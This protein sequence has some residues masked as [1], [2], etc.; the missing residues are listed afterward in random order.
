MI[1]TNNFLLITSKELKLKTMNRRKFLKKSSTGVAAAAFLP[2]LS[3]TSKRYLPQDLYVAAELFEE[4]GRKWFFNF[5]ISPIYI[6]ENYNDTELKDK[7]LILEGQNDSTQVKLSYKIE[8]LTQKTIDDKRLYFIQYKTEK[9][10]M[11]A[12][13]Y[14]FAKEN[15]GKEIIL[16]IHDKCHA[17]IRNEKLKRELKFGFSKTVAEPECFLTTACVAH[18]GFPDDCKELT[19]LRNLRENVMKP[20]AKYN[21][22]ISEYEI[23]APKMLINI[24]KSSNK[25]EVLDYIYTHLVQPSISY[26]ESGENE[27][28]IEHYTHFVQAMKAHYL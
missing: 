22:L 15:F 8:S 3:F 19:L 24:N 7:F 23:I 9:D 28:A 27:V 25:N 18:K 1:C 14:K 12:D 16:E 5:L 10:A 11:G 21:F 4:K 6:Y 2:L 13:D 20:N 17:T 26:I